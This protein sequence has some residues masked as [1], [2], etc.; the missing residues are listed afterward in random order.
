MLKTVTVWITTN[1][2]KFLDGN[3]RPFYLRNLCAGQEA[4]SHLG[5]PIHAHVSF[6][7]MEEIS[8]VVQWLRIHFP[9]QET[10]V[11]FLV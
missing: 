3:A 4:L 11:R 2:G 5:R 1:C 9:V 10:W 6:K 8:L 7:V